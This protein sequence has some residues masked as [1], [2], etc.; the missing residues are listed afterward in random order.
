M[1]VILVIYFLVSRVIRCALYW[2]LISCPWWSPCPPMGWDRGAFLAWARKGKE[3]GLR[4]Q[5]LPLR[6]SWLGEAETEEG[7]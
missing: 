6:G 3:C 2:F 4:S 1:V 7:Q 5:R